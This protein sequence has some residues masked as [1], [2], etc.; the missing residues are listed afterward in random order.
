MAEGQYLGHVIPKD[1]LGPF[2]DTYQLLDGANAT[3][4][5]T[6]IRTET[7]K[8][9]SVEIYGTFSGTVQLRGTNQ[10]NPASSD[11]GFQFGSNITAPGQAVLT[12]PCRWV[13]AKVTAYT[14]G[15]ISAILHGVG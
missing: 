14:S 8:A 7:L 9:A 4:S 15:S 1:S 6:W 13:K 10:L 11:D 3:E 12:M 5:G 2:G